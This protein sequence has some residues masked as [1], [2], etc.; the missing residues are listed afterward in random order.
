MFNL[1][2]NRLYLYI[3]PRVVHNL[4]GRLRVHYSAMERL[5]SR[6]H[7]F[8]APVAELVNI[9]QGIQD[10]NI[11]PTTGKVLITYD[12]DAL[13]DKDILKW[14]ESIIKIKIR[15]PL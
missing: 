4:P 13:G 15:K 1:F 3:A 5:S 9:K 7:R 6:W 2:K 14:L 11:Q 10:T 8:S 12:A